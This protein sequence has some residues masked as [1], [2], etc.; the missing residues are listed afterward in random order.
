MFTL[1][2]EGLSR[3]EGSFSAY[4]RRMG[5]LVSKSKRSSSLKPG[6]GINTTGSA[7]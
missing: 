2:L 1:S 5:M 3:L 7:N 6:S 4:D